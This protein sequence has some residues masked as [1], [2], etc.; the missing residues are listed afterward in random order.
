MTTFALVLRVAV[1]LAV[2]LLLV[3]VAG[4]MLQRSGSGGGRRR[5][6]PAEVEVLYRQPVSRRAAVQ[7]VRAGRRALV[8]GVTDHT[9]TLLAEDEADV[10]VPIAPD[11]PRTAL[12]EGAPAPMRPTWTN[13]V[14]AM[15]DRTVRRR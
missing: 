15:R 8:L 10:L 11:V 1:S 14:D 5:R 4:G 6:G 7:V 3:R 9:I 13:L 12:R 2:V